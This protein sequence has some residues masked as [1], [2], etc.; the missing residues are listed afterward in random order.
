MFRRQKQEVH[1][2]ASC[3][4]CTTAGT[5]L[6]F[7]FQYCHSN[8]NFINVTDT[9]STVKSCQS[10]AVETEYHVGVNICCVIL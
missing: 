4:A 6:S 1:D 10:L 5:Y 9:S 8:T 2:S 7:T 3:H